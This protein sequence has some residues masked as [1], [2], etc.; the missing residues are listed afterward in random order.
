M[1]RV[2]APNSY[3]DSV[4][5]VI[6]ATVIPKQE[7]KNHLPL[8]NKKAFGLLQELVASILLVLSIPKNT[9]IGP[10]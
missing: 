2:T 4:E 5:A 3:F 8:F 6:F 7:T 1:K 9:S 10:K